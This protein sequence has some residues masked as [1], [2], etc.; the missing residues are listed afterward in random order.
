[1]YGNMLKMA[2]YCEKN[3][4]DDDDDSEAKTTFTHRQLAVVLRLSTGALFQPG[5]IQ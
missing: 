3:F 2:T 1:M 5:M 4:S